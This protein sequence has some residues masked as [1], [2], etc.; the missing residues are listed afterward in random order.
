M[1]WV[2]IAGTVGF[3]ILAVSVVLVL[4][5]NAGRG[6]PGPRP[7]KG[8]PPNARYGFAESLLPKATPKEWIDIS[9][10]EGSKDGSGWYNYVWLSYR[11]ARTP[12]L[13]GVMCGIIQDQFEI[14]IVRTVCIEGKTVRVPIGRPAILDDIEGAK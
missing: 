3:G 7:V 5:S 11:G 13:W 8:A 9:P 10:I 12:V 2:V 14:D 1:E 4:R 6:G